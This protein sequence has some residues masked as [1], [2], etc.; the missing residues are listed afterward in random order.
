MGP[1]KWYLFSYRRRESPLDNPDSR[2]YSSRN[3][4]AV[5]VGIISGSGT[6]QWPSLKDTDEESLNTPYGSV[7]ATHGEFGGSQIIHISRHGR[8]HPRLS[9][10]VNHRANLTALI[11]AGVDAIISLTVCG[12]VDKEIPLGAV[13]AFDDLYFPSNRLPDG[14]LCSWYD[15]PGVSRRGHWI[16]THP[17]SEPL[18]SAAISFGQAG[19]VSVVNGGCYGH[20][21]GPRFNSKAEIRALASVGVTAI[22]QTAG[23]EVVLAGEAE[24]PFV[25]LGYVTDYANGVGDEPEPIE[26][27]I[28]RVAESTQVL[29]S[30]VEGTLSAISSSDLSPAGIVYRFES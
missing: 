5:L 23:P 24:V 3:G 19:G 11:E 7:R 21:D 15:S 1:A 18:R 29:S 17:F 26:A 30:V 28:A 22:S 4:S 8:G 12:A 2:S 27:L 10:H 14:S 13:V 6:E 16:F 25:L 9:S 20:V